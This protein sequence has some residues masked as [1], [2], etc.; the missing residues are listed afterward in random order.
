MALRW[1]DRHDRPAP[2]Y[3]HI[4]GPSTG[5]TYLQKLLT[6]NGDTLADDGFLLPG[7]S[8]RDVVLATHDALSFG[9]PEA[10]DRTDLTRAAGGRWD[11]LAEEMTA[12]RGKATI[13]SINK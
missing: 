2:I 5:T 13:V 11:R 3:L 4:G 7:E 12:H 6:A 9:R 10:I 1:L 8:W